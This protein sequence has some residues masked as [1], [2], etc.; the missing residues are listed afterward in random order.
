[1]VES[2]PKEHEIGDAL[3]MS[4]GDI[5][6]MVDVFR[7]LNNPDV[8][9]NNAMRFLCYLIC[10]KV[11]KIDRPTWIPSFLKYGQQYED[12]MKRFFSDCYDNPTAGI[13]GLLDDEIEK[14]V[15]D[16]Y[17]WCLGFGYQFQ[18]PREELNDAELRVK[19]LFCLYS[20]ESPKTVYRDEFSTFAYASYLMGL[21]FALQTNLSHFF[22]EAIGF[23][24]FVALVSMNKLNYQ[25][26][27][28]KYTEEH[29]NKLDDLVKYFLP[30]L[31]KQL[32]MLDFDLESYI[33]HWETT[34]YCEEH[35]PLNLLLVWDQI[36]FHSEEFQF[37][38]NFLHVSHL[39]FMVDNNTDFSSKK[40]L[41]SVPWNAVFI[42]NQTD[43]LME[44][45]L[46]RIRFNYWSFC[47]CY[48]LCPSLRKK[49]YS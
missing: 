24:M 19:R 35:V 40:S 48:G 29:L 22:A 41:E 10:L 36:F 23:Q 3:Y 34:L 42:L 47:P 6:N 8:N 43:E 17:N 31:R 20:H 46:G 33:F 32:Q 13:R 39:K 16:K 1:M 27:D 21:L 18:I 37:F 11:L 12:S 30:K 45:D 2:F 9:K 4:A 49:K 38:I 7:F 26:Q 28:L 5:F 44:K 25:L 15:K 14:G